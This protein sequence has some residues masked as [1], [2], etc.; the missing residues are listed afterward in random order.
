VGGRCPIRPSVR[1]PSRQPKGGPCHRRNA[2]KSTGPKTKKGKE[3]ASQNS[4]THGLYAR[5]L[6]LDSPHLK[7]DQSEYNSL[8]YS[9]YQELDPEGIFEEFLVRKIANCLW[10]SRRV[11]FAENAQITRQLQGIDRS[12]ENHAYLMASLDSDNADDIVSP[13]NLAR[14][15]DYMIGINSL[16]HNTP[17]FNIPRWEMR[18]DRQITRTMKTLAHLQRRRKSKSADEKKKAPQK[19]DQTNPNPLQVKGK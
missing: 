15:R 5:A 6:I 7:E 17:S 13:E 12:A 18:L 3:I 1:S 10:R 4:V 2:Q 14:I 9:L 11:I 16:P 8:V 19:N